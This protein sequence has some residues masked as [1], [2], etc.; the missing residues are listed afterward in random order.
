MKKIFGITI[1]FI[2]IPYLIVNI[3]TTKV[4]ISFKHNENKE[5]NVRVKRLASNKIEKIPFE[6]YIEGVLAS[7]VPVSFEME[8]L[9]AQAVAARSYALKK[10]ENSKTDEYDLVD[11]VSNQV[12]LNEEELKNKWQDNYEKYYE[13]I[14][15]AVNETKGEYLEYNGEV[16]NAFFFS[17]SVGKTENCEEVFQ[18]NLPYLKSVDSSWDKDNSPVFNDTVEMSLNEFYDKLNLEFNDN[19]NIEVLET[20]ST[21][22]IKKIVINNHEL[23]GNEIAKNLKLRSN[24]F[25]IE[26]IDKT[27]KITTTGYGHGV[28]LSQYGSNGMAKEG[29]KYDEILK[30]YYT[31]VNIKKLKN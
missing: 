25:K 15:T 22:R 24:Y 26:K 13:K 8:A 3:I 28:G 31:G 21:G 4:N 30:H 1:L 12:Y 23:T 27:I 19:I 6:K 2:L 17:T 29:Y 5:I 11:S 20:T 16:I 18:E 10:M 14:K 7:E 9:K